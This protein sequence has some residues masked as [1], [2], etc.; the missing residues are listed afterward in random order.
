MDD[1]AVGARLAPVRAGAEAAVP[2]LQ[3]RPRDA[4]RAHVQPLRQLVPPQGRLRPRPLVFV[5][6][7]V[8]GGRRRRK[9]RE[10]QLE[11]RARAARVLDGQPAVG[12]VRQ[13]V[14]RAAQALR[15][16]GESVNE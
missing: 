3:L 9:G 14:R 8:F 15:R 6:V 7:L 5:L 4:A 1:S 11:R 10:G 13:A 12:Q 2:A 16:R